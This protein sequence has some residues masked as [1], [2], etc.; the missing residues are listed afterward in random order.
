MP[1][2]VER[3]NVKHT[4]SAPTAGVRAMTSSATVSSSEMK[5]C[6]SLSCAMQAESSMT[7]T[8]EFPSRRR[9]PRFFC[10]TMNAIKIRA[11]SCPLQAMAAT[12]ACAIFFVIW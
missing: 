7:M 5:L 10:P 8:G 12:V 2:E 9:L 4:K 6:P 11:A 3:S 1:L